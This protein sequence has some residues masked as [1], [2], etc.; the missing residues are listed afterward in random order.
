LFLPLSLLLSRLER[1]LQHGQ[2]GS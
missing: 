1:R 2:F